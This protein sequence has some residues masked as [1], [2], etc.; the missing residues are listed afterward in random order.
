MCKPINV[1]QFPADVMGKLRELA[2]LADNP[3]TDTNAGAVR[4]AALSYTEANQSR[5]LLRRQGQRG[6]K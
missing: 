4:W 2:R 5:L 1:T 6:A 3:P